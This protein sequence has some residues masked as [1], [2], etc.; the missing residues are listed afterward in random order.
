LA[1]S[2]TTT[3]SWGWR[4]IALGAPCTPQAVGELA[5]AF[6][7]L[8]VDELVFDPTVAD[9]TRSTGSR[10]SSSKTPTRS[11]PGIYEPWTTMRT[12]E[13]LVGRVVGA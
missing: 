10:S 8:D 4:G 9:V 7:E 3:G 2:A 11:S 6:E 12:E 13:P 5:T 1:T